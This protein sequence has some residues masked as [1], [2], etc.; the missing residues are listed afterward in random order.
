MRKPARAPFLDVDLDL[1]R[2]LPAS[3][4]TTT[5]QQAVR[6][7]PSRTMKVDGQ[8]PDCGI[9]QLNVEKSAAGD[10]LWEDEHWCGVMYP[11]GHSSP[12]PTQHPTAPQHHSTT[13]TQADWPTGCVRHAGWSTSRTRRRCPAG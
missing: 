9:C 7:P 2:S 1:A 3:P 5:Q 12:H 13:R 11:A 8:D 4:R 10:I 6:R